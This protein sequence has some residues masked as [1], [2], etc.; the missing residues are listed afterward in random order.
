[1][2][3]PR[4]DE[5]GYRSGMRLVRPGLFVACVALQAALAAV[6]PAAAQSPQAG[7]AVVESTIPAG[8]ASATN[9]TVAAGLS[10]PSLT[11]RAF[12]LV[13]GGVHQ[14]ATRRTAEILAVGGVLALAGK[15]I[16]NPT[17]DAN[18]FERP[19]FDRSADFGNTYGEAGVLAGTAGLIAAGWIVGNDGIK[20]T[21]L[22]LARSLVYAGAITLPLKVA[23]NRRRPNGG[24]YSFPSGHSAAAFAVAPVLASRLGPRLGA[25]AYLAAATT[26][27]GRVEEHKH[28]L[29]DVIFGASVGLASGFAVTGAP[30]GPSLVA[31]PSGI[32]FGIR[33]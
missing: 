31:G 24:K 12:G 22:D 7:S 26:A 5:R 17:R 6:S 9:P 32:G 16:E 33:F 27:I 29:S 11:H 15:Q 20:N 13:T 8:F 4:G 18:F 28:Y 3:R 23:V 2:T 14:L 30:H 1:M 21:G 10:P 25:L 19:T